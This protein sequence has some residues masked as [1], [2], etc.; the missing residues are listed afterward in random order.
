RA[1]ERTLTERIRDGYLV[2]A[3]ERAGVGEDR[4]DLAAAVD[5]GLDEWHSV[6]ARA[7][8]ITNG[9]A[10]GAIAAA[11]V[12]EP[13]ARRT[14]VRAVLRLALSRAAR[15]SD[16]RI[17]QAVVS[18]ASALARRVVS[19]RLGDAVDRG[20]HEGLGRARE[21]VSER[22]QRSLNRLP[23][24]LPIL[25][26]G[27]PWWVTVNVWYVEAVGG[28]DRFAVS[29]ATGRPTA[30]GA[31]LTYVRDGSTVAIDYDDDGHRERFGRATRVTFRTR[32]AVAIAVPPGARG[33]GDKGGDM[34]EA[35]AGWDAWSGAASRTTTVPAGWL[36]RGPE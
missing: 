12:D 9:S 30:P 18:P 20:L 29:A 10:A 26:I 35:S 24:G 25:P 15:A 19:R 23:A 2:A 21:R 32:T 1:V 7:M 22:L 6:G 36:D 16:T 4:A 8:A 11:A 28:Y 17:P 31:E 13:G 5:R 27:T 34:H 14:R 33:V 3:L